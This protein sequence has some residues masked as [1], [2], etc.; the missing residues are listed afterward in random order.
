MQPQTNEVY[1]GRETPE[2]VT[3]ETPLEGLETQALRVWLDSSR[4]A[5]KA[6]Q[7]NPQRVEQAVRQRV[8][9]AH[10]EELCAYA[11]WG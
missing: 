6:H 10:V 7:A 4:A 8:H 3:S 11:A 2:P 9:A 1:P 5:R